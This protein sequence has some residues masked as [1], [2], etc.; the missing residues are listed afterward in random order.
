MKIVCAIFLF[1]FFLAFCKRCY[2]NVLFVSSLSVSIKKTRHVDASDVEC[3]E[4]GTN[5]LSCA[6]SSQRK[7]LSS[8]TEGFV[9][10]SR[11]KL[12]PYQDDSLQVLVINSS[13]SRF[14]S[15]FTAK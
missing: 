4:T 12:H 8:K 9:V 5:S 10:I 15:W 3:T 14:S 13:H 1:Y 2:L 6:F 11:S 7:R